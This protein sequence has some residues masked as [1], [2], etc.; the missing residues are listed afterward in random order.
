MRWFVPLH[1]LSVILL[2]ATQT[3][4]TFVLPTIGKKHFETNDWQ[5]LL[6]TAP[7]TILF[8]LSIFWN[9]FFRRMNFGVYMLLN[10][11]VSSLP[12]AAIS[13]TDS[14]VPL[15]ALFL[16]SCCGFAGYHPASGELLKRL[17]PDKSRG[18]M[19]SIVHAANMIGGAWMV[20]EIGNALKANPEAF[21]WIFPLASGLQLLGTGGFA[22]LAA[23]NPR[24]VDPNAWVSSLAT[25]RTPWIDRVLGPITHM[26]ETLRADP[27]FA[28][29]EAAYMTYGVGWMIAYALL[30]LIMI[31][32]L[33]LDYDQIPR[34]SQTPYLIA[35]VV[36][37]APAGWLMDRLGPMRS[38]GLSFAAL[39]L[40]P[41]GLI[42]ACQTKDPMVLAGASVLYGLAHAGASVGWMLGPVGLA[43][44]PDKVPHYVAIHATL[45]G[46]RG[47]IFQG[48]GVVL[49]KLTGSFTPPLILAAVAYLWSSQQMWSLQKAVKVRLK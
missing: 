22:L 31:D 30:P 16:I 1:I 39:A 34:H 7:P 46:L 48:A 33:H 18:R 23:K 29:Y 43:P 28:R 6:L 14:Y 12:I 8:V 24:P 38:T 42:I 2:Q 10:W 9:D 41:I 27:V 17:Y 35:M 44:T 21:R 5:T 37:L 20:Y 49:Y 47:A 11:A 40:H 4:I 26:K 13:L 3:T 45:V 15:E 25:A 32:G 19:Y 36:A